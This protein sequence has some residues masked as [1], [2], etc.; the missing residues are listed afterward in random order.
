MIK[1]ILLFIGASA[2]LIILG[3]LVYFRLYQNLPDFLVRTLP[4]I[5]LPARGEKIM[6]F[7]PHP[8]DETLGAGGFIAQA[9]QNGAEVTVV[10]LTNGDGH[11][12]SS[13]EE[14]R[15]F[16]PSVD[17]YVQSGY[18]RQKED[19]NALQVLGVPVGNIIFL[20]YPDGGL[21]S[22]LTT[23]W[24]NPYESPYTKQTSSLYTNSYHQNASYTGENL[25]NDLVNIL[26]KYQ[27]SLVLATSQFDIHPD[28]AAT[29]NFVKKATEKMNGPRP[30][31]YYYLIHFRHFPS[32]KG[33]HQN[34]ALA[35]PTKIMKKYINVFKLSLNQNDENTQE[36][37]INEYRSQLKSPLLK[38]LMEG[39]VR[40]NEL[41]FK[42]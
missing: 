33:L 24:Q 37:A 23:N 39:F 3:M 17:N 16:Y 32:P 14:F 12:F 36:K 5:T 40:Q 15:K 30:R 19:Q 18:D 29:G 13:V 38:G 42:D 2:I 10:M 26:S 4:E 21:K 22:L 6:I 28:H 1:K 8:D 34:R 11:R 20:G 31:L 25:E 7:S 35:P 9:L 27:P 41:F